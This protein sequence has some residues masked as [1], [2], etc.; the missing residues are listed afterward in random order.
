MRGVCVVSVLSMVFVC[1]SVRCVS[2]HISACVYICKC[3]V[4][5]C[6]SE[7]RTHKKF[8]LFLDMF[9]SYIHKKKFRCHVFAHFS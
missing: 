3:E 1:V 8:E 9:S 4:T 2:R 6:V 7:L 5:L